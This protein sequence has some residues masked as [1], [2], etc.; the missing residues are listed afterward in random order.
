MTDWDDEALKEINSL[1]SAR[2][3]I[4]G[5]L[6]TIRDLQDQ[7]G[8]LKAEV[9][10]ESARRKASES[11]IGDLK[12]VIERWQEQAKEWETAEKRR[13]QEEERYRASVRLQVRSEER[14]Q[15]QESQRR[16]EED[17]SKLQAELQRMAQDHLQKEA[18]WGEVKKRLEQREGELVQAEREKAEMANRYRADMEVVE[19]LRCARDRE[20]AASVKSRELELDDRNREIAGLR[21]EGEDL[22]AALAALGKD[23]Q[24]KLQESQDK[25]AKD[26]QL[27]ERVLQERYAKRELELQ[28]SWSE[29]ESGLWK[30][31]KD[32][33]EKLDKAAGQQF[34]ERARALADRSQ[35]IEQHL[36]HRRLEL[37]GDFQRRCKEAESRYAE[38]ERS[39]KAGWLEKEDRFLKKFEAELA[40]EKERVAAEWSAKLKELENDRARLELGLQQRREELEREVAHQKELL[41][42]ENARKDAER[43]RR[44][45][46]FV[47]R[48]SAELERIHQQRI[49]ELAQRQ[50][51]IEAQALAAETARL[52]A[53]SDFK[54]NAEAELNQ[55]R[56]ELIDANA[57]S[58]E[59]A[60]QAVD[61][62]FEERVRTL[63]AAY[64]AKVGELDRARKAAEDQLIEFRAR[65]AAEFSIKEK[66]LDSRWSAREQ[67]LVSRYEGQLNAQRSD[68]DARLTALREEQQARAAK[69]QA[70]FAG[71]KQ[72]L[73]ARYDQLES[74][75]NLKFAAREDELRGSHE[76]Q[77]ADAAQARRKDLQA[78]AQAM[79]AEREGLRRE[80]ET[81]RLGARDVE[82]ELA[83]ALKRLSVQAQ[84][85][86][87]QRRVWEEERLS[88]RRQERQDRAEHDARYA[89]LERALK[90]DW[91]RKEELL[92]KDHE[93]A[94]AKRR[95]ELERQAQVESARIQE[96]AAR[97]D[98]EVAR[99]QD[100]FVANKSS[101][102]AARAQAAEV[103]RR[104]T[105]AEESR[106]AQAELNARRIALIDTNAKTLEESRLALERQFEERI[107]ALDAAYAA[108]VGEL[109]RAR[110]AGEEQIL[111][112]KVK[113]A[114]EEARKSDDFT[115]RWAAREQELSARFEAD[116]QAEQDD[117]DARLRQE[118]ALRAQAESAAADQA[119]WRAAAE[120]TEL[121]AR[122]LQ[123]RLDEAAQRLAAQ[124]KDAQEQQR[125]WQSQRLTLERHYEDKAVQ[126]EEE[127]RRQF[128]AEVTAEKERL[129]ALWSQRLKEAAE[130]SARAKSALE[131]DAA[132]KQ[133]ERASS[134]E[135]AFAEKEKNLEGRWSAREKELIGSY[136]A[137]LKD[138]WDK[139]QAQ[140]AKDQAA[141]LDRR[142]ELEDRQE[143]L[144]RALREE[145]AAREEDLR[146]RH[147]A[148][149]QAQREELERVLREELGTGKT[150]GGQTP[151]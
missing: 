57:K 89:E 115:A 43:V 133:A 20:I 130:E 42:E 82:T 49:T 71:R 29:L 31:A 72:E 150:G 101:E 34:E 37:D 86:E 85:F 8:K 127:L 27:K 141:L 32:A 21:R 120:E 148:Q 104:R 66:N 2:L 116:R 123:S 90:D 18:R 87:A 118:K 74:S 93:T 53:A 136:E 78:Q 41:L 76:I 73:E 6:A 33:R 135:A 109:E 14:L 92:L 48:E 106:E 98:A 95:A 12:A 47:A 4:R 3:A 143:R 68:F 63:D 80:L 45:D 121:R 5:A 134:L 144:E 88:I 65:V 61:K 54:R 149:L 44:Q 24:L 62:Q 107:A 119:R 125:L 110:K 1:D 111:Q 113:L 81:S 124:F 26:F 40:A 114:S 140:A 39:L 100:E 147:E 70:E 7:T 28:S 131:E 126:R 79:A 11:Q 10:D 58:L 19:S 13:A 138:L 77:L 128:E 83:D 105:A 15:I 52:Q 30:R 25:L 145:F 112:F 67:E 38:N 60:R 46:E 75:L 99:L 59:L 132:G 23:W 56:I 22:K 146:R 91:A 9:R 55:R 142:Q 108:K 64:A 139:Q 117:F 51:E 17:L 96:E 84:E 137:R 129:G 97:R 151:G 36:E 50:T 94:L 103:E 102:L 35:E 122:G 16:L 69:E